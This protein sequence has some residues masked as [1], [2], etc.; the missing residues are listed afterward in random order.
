MSAYAKTGQR[1]DGDALVENLKAEHG[2]WIA[3]S[4]IGEVLTSGRSEA[5]TGGRFE[6][7]VSVR[8]DE[9]WA[10]LLFQRQGLA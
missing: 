6:R 10:S 5:K 3:V 2:A 1:R 9:A 7:A 8:L 4:T